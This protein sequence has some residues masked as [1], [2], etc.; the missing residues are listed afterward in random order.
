MT[1]RCVRMRTVVSA[2]MAKVYSALT[3]YRQLVDLVDGL[4]TLDPVP[5]PGAL[6]KSANGAAE[7][8]ARFAAR[9]DV[10]AHKVEDTL[11]LSRLA[12]GELVIW[13]SAGD[14]S[15]AL[16]FELRPHEDAS[17][18]SVLLSVSYEEP[19]GWKGL[20][21]APVIEQA[22]RSRARKTLVNLKAAFA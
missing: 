8:G 4:E 1:A 16:S 22:V 5:A 14:G 13:E 12:P 21:L 2:G 20:L 3:D 6:V 15:R 17:R 19:E 7:Q 11:V 18:T 9:L 10:G